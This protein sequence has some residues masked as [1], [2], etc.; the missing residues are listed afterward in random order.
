MAITVSTSTRFRHSEVFMY[1][2][3]GLIVFLVILLI[4]PQQYTRG[5]NREVGT[6]GIG[7]RDLYFRTD[8]VP[9]TV[10]P[11]V[12]K[13]VN[14][15]EKRAQEKQDMLSRSEILEILSGQ[16]ILSNTVEFGYVEHICRVAQITHTN[17]SHFTGVF[18]VLQEES[19]YFQCDS[20]VK[21]QVNSHPVPSLP[22]IGSSTGVYSWQYGNH[23]AIEYVSGENWL[24]EVLCVLTNRGNSYTVEKPVGAIT[25]TY[26][27]PEIKYNL[28][29]P[30]WHPIR[31]MQILPKEACISWAPSTPCGLEKLEKSFVFEKTKV[32]RDVECIVVGNFQWAYYIP[33]DTPS[34]IWGEESGAPKAKHLSE[35]ALKYWGN[36]RTA[37]DFDEFVQISENFE[38]PLRI[39]EV[40][41]SVDGD[42]QYQ[43]ETNSVITTGN[44][45]LDNLKKYEPY[46]LVD[47]VN[48]NSHYVGKATG[49]AKDDTNP[50]K[51]NNSFTSII[52]INIIV[53]ASLFFLMWRKKASSNA[54][55]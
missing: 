23:K 38:V 24:G 39:K 7:K 45:K 35:I 48:G 26:Y 50:G 33:R 15:L 13:V 37:K 3:L 25:S 2:Y 9:P 8:T 5:D 53:L 12:F 1:Q 43:I 21:W 31:Q 40:C 17:T 32:V 20:T 47:A 42:I 36:N 51:H 10:S 22:P 6:I 55:G 11:E 14:L 49:S 27:Q 19:P 30:R 29:Y 4:S 44:R 34:R 28:L 16:S 46:Y 18:K 54:N 41:I 52:I